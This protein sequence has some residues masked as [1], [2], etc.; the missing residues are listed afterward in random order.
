MILTAAGLPH[1]ETKIVPNSTPAIQ[2]RSI[3]P[4][5]SAASRP[6]VASES[7]HSE[8]TQ[9][10]SAQSKTQHREIAHQQRFPGQRVPTR[11]RH[12]G[13]VSLTCL[14]LGECPHSSHGSFTNPGRTTTNP[15]RVAPLW[16]RDHQ[17]GGRSGSGSG[18]CVAHM[19]HAFLSLIQQ[20]PGPTCL[21][22]CG[23]SILL[24]GVRLHNSHFLRVGNMRGSGVRSRARSRSQSSSWHTWSQLIALPRL[25][26]LL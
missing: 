1:T 26:L 4:L 10:S 17:L 3:C 8:A 25:V 11:N 16:W 20:H 9:Q 15:P 5:V 6:S 21:L 7:V 18:S 24:P 19:E 2:S 23:H 14:Y 13:H 12:R 22:H